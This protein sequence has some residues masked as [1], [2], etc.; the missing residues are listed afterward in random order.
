MRR[1]LRVLSLACAVG[2]I[3]TAK[4]F[5]VSQTINYQAVLTSGGQP[6]SSPV[7]VIFSV[8][9]APTG[10]TAVWAETLSVAPDTQGRLSIRLGEIHPLNE[11][12]FP[13]T[14]RWLGVQVESDPEMTRHPL[15][16]APYSFRVSTIDSASGGTI[17]GN[18]R[19]IDNLSV[20]QV[21]ITVHPSNG[22]ILSLRDPGGSWTEHRSISS[23]YY[24]AGSTPRTQV[25]D[26]G[27]IVFG[28]DEFDTA[29]VVDDA[30]NV[31]AVGQAIFGRNNNVALA[32]KGANGAMLANGAGLVAGDANTLTGNNASAIGDSNT[33]AG[34][35]ALAVGKNNVIEAAAGRSIALGDSNRINLEDGFAVGFGNLVASPRSGAFGRHIGVFGGGDNFVFGEASYTAGTGDGVIGGGIYDTALHAAVPVIAGGHTNRIIGTTAPNNGNFFSTI[36]GGHLNRIDVTT[37]PVLDPGNSTIAGGAENLIT[38]SF[39]A[40]GGG[41]GNQVSGQFSAIAG[42]NS[43]LINAA[44]SSI[45]GGANG[46]ITSTGSGSFIGAGGGAV[47]EGQSS[48]VCGGG[49]PG[50]F[51]FRNIARGDQSFVGAG[52]SNIIES[53][54]DDYSAIVGGANNYIFKNYAFIGGGEAD[55]ITGSHG[56]IIGGFGNRVSGDYGFASGHRAKSTHH[57]TF[58][59]ADHT[60]ADFAS[61]GTDQFL[62]RAGG[63]FGINTAS[64]SS[65]LQVNGPVATAVATLSSNTTLDG[66]HSVVLVT[67]SP[68]TVTLPAASS[69]SG[70]H[71]TIKKT[72][73]GASAVTVSASGSDVIDGAGTF[74]LSAQYKYVALVSDGANWFVVANN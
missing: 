70:R 38:R 53:T 56:M 15:A 2:T 25:G 58:V 71:L 23:T 65:V 52:I 30:G 72:D 46:Q 40:I 41:Q 12:V 51:T 54:D 10:G 22:P 50:N 67:S 66:T 6:V 37:D 43:N 13:G 29:A 45:A 33:V 74:S 11:S 73:S 34:E 49:V 7:E 1:C 32:V 26:G 62:V 27:M 35:N 19:L 55:T 39:G 69:C 57:G 63:G 17:K 4:V 24:G 60:N 9:E 59:W 18:V 8:Y 3:M 48:V 42:G 5:A 16:S 20:E 68:V 64:P 36:G 31:V 47:C 61:T 14:D 28:A 44:Y 21:A